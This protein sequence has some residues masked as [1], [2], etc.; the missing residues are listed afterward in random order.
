MTGMLQAVGLA[1]LWTSV[2][3]D[4]TVANMVVGFVLG[5]IVLMFAERVP[6]FKTTSRRI[7]R[8]GALLLHFLWELV[9]SNL[10]MAYIVVSPTLPIEPGVVAVPLDARSDAEITLLANLI[11]LTPGTMSLEVSDDRHVLYVHTVDAK[12]RDGL[13]RS[14][15]QGFER[16][17]LE[18]LR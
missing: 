1:L 4:L 15:K 9:L 17:V 5:Y 16:R 6:G 7:W 3:G 12:D 13:I 10:K 11:T 2:T 18:V 14:I 8:T